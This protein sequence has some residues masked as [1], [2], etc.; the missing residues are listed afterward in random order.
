MKRVAFITIHV[1]ANFGSVLQTIATSEV[2]K[3]IGAEPL[4]VNYIPERVTMKKFW[5]FG[6][7]NLIKK[8]L[9]FFWKLYALPN[10]LLNNRSYGGYLK[11]HCR[12]SSPIYIEDNFTEKCPKADVYMTGSDQV[13][14][15]KHNEGLDTHYFF[16]G[17]VGKKV[18]FASSIG[19]LD[20]GEKNREEYK[21]F[22]SEYSVL[23][24]REDSAVALLHELG[25]NAE[26]L[27][28]P[29]FML[30]KEEWIGFVSKNKSIDEPYILIYTPYNT[31]DKSVI[32]NHARFIAKKEGLKIVTFSWTYYKDKD[33]D[34]TIRFASPGDFLNLIMGAEYVITNSFHGTAFSINLNKK[35]WVFLPSGFSSRITSVL[36]KFG[37]AE[38]LVEEYKV[39][40]NWD[41]NK[42]IDY[43]AVNLVLKKERENS[44]AFLEKAIL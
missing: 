34:K 13:W 30:D 15:I 41:Y 20:I 44:F 28:D 33:A 26:R 18:S 29:I 12:L 36:S 7:A 2:I 27:L 5:A 19:Y 1:G 10:K 8:A 11:K 6:H 31:V 4:C 38:R 21:R 39:S 3:R 42:S 40:D 25:L 37:L 43:K 14:N 16:E 32:F 24:V 17:I 9:L 22:L 35:F 23:S